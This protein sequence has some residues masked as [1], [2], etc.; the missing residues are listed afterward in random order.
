LRITNGFKFRNTELEIIFEVFNLMD[1]EN[2]YIPYYNFDP[3]LNYKYEITNNDY[4]D[5]TR[6][7]APRQYQLGMRFKF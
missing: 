4:G 6:P 1:W 5:A 2:W 3:A 7:G